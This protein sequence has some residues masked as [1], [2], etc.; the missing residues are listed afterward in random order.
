MYHL[1]TIFKQVAAVFGRKWFWMKNKLK[2]PKLN[3][4][5]NNQEFK[6]KG[7]SL[8]TRQLLGALFNRI[9]KCWTLLG[10]IEIEK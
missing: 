9:K 1:Y 2:W 7:G 8:E 6:V 3:Y 10:Y 5:G 4:H